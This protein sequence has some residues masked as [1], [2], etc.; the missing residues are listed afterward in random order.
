[1]EVI[2]G[3]VIAYGPDQISLRLENELDTF[4]PDLVIVSVFSGN[5]FGDNIRNKIYRLNSEG[6]LIKNDYFLN[7]KLKRLK[8]VT[9]VF[10]SLKVYFIA[11]TTLRKFISP[12]ETDNINAT[13]YR[14]AT[15]EI[16]TRDCEDF[17]VNKNNEVTNLFNDG[18]DSD[19][20]LRPN[21]SCTLYK[22]KLM[23]EIIKH[24]NNLS[25]SKNVTF[26]LMIIP[27]NQRI[28]HTTYYA[29]SD[30]TLWD[31]T[32]VNISERNDVA[33]LDLH[34]TFRKRD[35]LYFVTDS[36]WNDAGQEL[37]AELMAD[38]LY[39]MKEILPWEWGKT[40]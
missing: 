23:E 11:F 10:P 36:H 24:M 30:I 12:G 16:R 28:N 6:E 26:M 37:A 15:L 21:S 22:I 39:E 5:D 14:N 17:I 1:V 2:N 33:Y 35:S 3:G 18:F 29:E 32:L 7:P 27:V 19:M 38:S 25:T 13:I 31:D 4:K 40:T 8:K 9:A 34:P 20:S